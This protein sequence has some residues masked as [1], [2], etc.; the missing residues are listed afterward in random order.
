M[1]RI[2]ITGGIG[3]G[4]SVVAALLS[5][6]GVPVYIA[7][8]ESKRL[9]ATSAEIR[10][11]LTAL[12]GSDLYT[13]AGINKQ[14]LASYIFA[15]PEYMAKVN[16]IIHPVVNSDFQAWAARQESKAC[17]IESAILFE[18]GFDRL[19]DVRLMVYAPL[20]VRIDRALARDAASREEIGRRINSQMPDE[21]KRDRSD[22]VILNDGIHALVPQ[23]KKF[24]SFIF[25]C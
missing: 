24:I 14:L 17:A 19:V 2:G 11:R 9:L 5:L 8:T 3:S 18:S 21:I 23:V 25:S 12:F 22:Y 16:A 4:K 15:N 10:E 13:A 7:D 1:I 20:D 6:S